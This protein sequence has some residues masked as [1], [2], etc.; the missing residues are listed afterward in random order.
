MLAIGAE[1]A[2]QHRPRLRA[3]QG[4]GRGRA[5]RHQNIRLASCRGGVLHDFGAGFGQKGVGH[6]GPLPRA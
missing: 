3:V 4:F 5:D 2:D 1:Q 6:A